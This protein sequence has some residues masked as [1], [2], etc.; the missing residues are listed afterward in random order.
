MRVIAMSNIHGCYDEMMALLQHVHYNPKKDK[1][2]ILG[3]LMDYGPKTLE[4]IKA[5]MKLKEKGAI[6]LRGEREQL[7]INAF[8]YNHFPSEER[9]CVTKNTVVYHYHD[10]PD[11]R[12]AH[13]E[14]LQSLPFYAVY[15]NYFFSHAGYDINFP[16]NLSY[17]LANQTFYQQKEE[18]EDSDKVYVFGYTPVF[19]LNEDQSMKL[20]KTSRMLGIDFGA[21][22]YPIGTLGIVV[23][24]PNQ[25]YY[26][27]S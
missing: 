12:K 25:A 14:F 7:Y 9:L 1:L 23:L 19:H 16:D 4:V 22:R 20:F 27:I 26:C 15:E 3:G 17:C 11:T 21:A 24:E 5:C 10:H 8:A 2:F 18:L 13:I 6:I